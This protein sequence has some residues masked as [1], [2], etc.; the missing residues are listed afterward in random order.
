M[1]K[2]Y[3]GYKKCQQERLDFVNKVLV[4]LSAI[5]T[6]VGVLLVLTALLIT[7]RCS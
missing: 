2:Y 1:F 6:L 4:G 7:L 3:L 5:G